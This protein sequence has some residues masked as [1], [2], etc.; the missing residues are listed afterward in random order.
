MINRPHYHERQTRQSL[1]HN[2]KTDTTLTFKPDQ[3]T[4]STNAGD[5]TRINRGFLTVQYLRLYD[6]PA[7]ENGIIHTHLHCTFALNPTLQPT[8]SPMLGQLLKILALLLNTA[9]RIVCD[10]TAHMSTQSEAGAT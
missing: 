7:T 6:K 2:R 5:T 10:P 3:S 9:L 4:T 1:I 8:G